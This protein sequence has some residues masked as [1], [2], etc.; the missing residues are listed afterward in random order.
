MSKKYLYE[1]NENNRPFQSEHIEY[2]VKCIVQFADYFFFHDFSEKYKKEMFP[3]QT[4]TCLF[5]FL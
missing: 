2:A 4:A 1:K 5:A 3:I